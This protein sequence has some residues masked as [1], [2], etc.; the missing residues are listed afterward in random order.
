MPSLATSLNHI[1]KNLVG[2]RPL[3]VGKVAESFT[4]DNLSLPGDCSKVATFVQ[5]VLT[6]LQG[7]SNSVMELFLA[8]SIAVLWRPGST[9]QNAVNW[10]VGFGAGESL[11]VN[12]KEARVGVAGSP[13]NTLVLHIIEHEAER[14]GVHPTNVDLETIEDEHWQKAWVSWGQMTRVQFGYTQAGMVEHV[15]SIRFREKGH[16][17]ESLCNFIT[18]FDTRVKLAIAHHEDAVRYAAYAGKHRDDLTAQPDSALT[19]SMAGFARVVLA[20]RAN[21]KY[22]WAVNICSR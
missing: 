16:E 20:L 2:S 15:F 21:T 6:K 19:D 22:A 4:K 14:L 10:W 12:N 3:T 18:R 8:L 7:F 9:D 1:S 5:Q 17:K 11:T 13:M